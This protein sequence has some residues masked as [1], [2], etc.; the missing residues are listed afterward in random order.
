MIT[1]LCGG[2]GAAKK[3]RALSLVVDPSTLT[4]IVM[5]TGEVLGGVLSPFFAGTLAD[6]F[7]LTAPLWL[8]FGCAIAAGVLALGLIE[9][10]PRVVARRRAD[11]ASALG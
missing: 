2:V 10:A 1:V 8:M 4:G 5:G 11:G 7:G 9:S 6:R 3:L